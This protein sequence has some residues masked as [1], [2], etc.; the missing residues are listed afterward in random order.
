[1]GCLFC[2]KEETEIEEK[3]IIPEV[4][5]AYVKRIIYGNKILIS[6]KIK[7]IV[8]NYYLV[9]SNINILPNK[10]NNAT[11]YLKDNILNKNIRIENIKYMDYNDMY[12][13]IYYENIN[14]NERMILNGYAVKHSNFIN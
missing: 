13:E 11:Y 14:I 10:N 1:M 9:L 6:Y 12:A 3:L 2:C 4:I 7:G 8:Y 5:N